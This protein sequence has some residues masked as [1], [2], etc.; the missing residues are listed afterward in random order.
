MQLGP[1]NRTVFQN[2]WV[3]SDLESACM[4]W[5][6]QMGIGPFFVSNYF[7]QARMGSLPSQFTAAAAISANRVS[8][9]ACRVTSSSMQPI[10]ARVSK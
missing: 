2:A 9:A 7:H 5:V 8:M 6:N 3:V 1:T 10:N 4:K